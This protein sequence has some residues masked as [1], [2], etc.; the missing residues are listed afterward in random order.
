MLRN[1]VH[2]LAIISLLLISAP[3]LAQEAQVQLQP[4]KVALAGVSTQ[5][6]ATGSIESLPGLAL[7]TA[8]QR[9]VA[10]IADNTAVF[11][12]LTLPKG[13]S[14]LDLELDG[15][16]V[17][18]VNLRVLPAW[19]S[20][21]PPLVAI[22]MTLLSRQVI[23]AL[24]LGVWFGSVA[25]IGFT[26]AGIFHGLLAT[27][28]VHV[29]GAV[30]DPSQAQVLLFSFMIGGMIGIVIKNGGMQGVVNIIVRFATDPRRG[31]LTTAFLGLAVFFDG[32]ANALVVGNTMRQV[33]DRL[34]ISREKLAYIVDST[35]APV[36]SVA[37]VSTW[38]GFQVGLIGTILEQIGAIR[39][40]AY[41]IFLNSV[42]Y[43]FYPWLTI[44]MVFMLATSGREF[45]PMRVAEE[46]AR[47]ANIGLGP[48][49][50]PE[51]SATEASKL[52]NDEQPPVRAINSVVP[53]L[54]L[55]AG[56][57]G[58]L[59]ATGTGDSIRDIIGT[60]D[61]NTALMWGSLLAV[62]VAVAMTICQRI[63]PLEE[64]V[65][66]WYSGLRQ[67]LHALI[68]LVLAWSLAAVVSELHTASYLVS[69]LGESL[70]PGLVP[71]MVF[72]LAAAT[73]FATGSSWAT[74]GIL[75]PLVMPL[76][77]AVLSA[78]GAQDQMHIMYSAVSCVISGAVLGD[79]ISPISD[80][81]ILSSMAAGC[82][83]IEHVRTQL[84]YALI[85]GAVAVVLGTVPAGYG[86]PWWI[87]MLFGVGTI[88]SI[89]RC[90]G[91]PVVVAVT[92]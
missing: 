58:G 80:T 90:V 27:Y 5:V 59:W 28:T 13:L 38:I 79:H 77:W 85:V 3:L 82:D 30:V 73:A 69:A 47:K 48:A 25:L 18:T 36:T 39:E 29:L 23:P 15:V 37:V 64:I 6:R 33:T 67:M 91:K 65:N 43:S 26:P 76:V 78:A 9:Y 20:I 11:A 81:T 51:A 75:M 62:T 54:V 50:S 53:I 72:V 19:V 68:I 63:L 45:G 84:P 52:H 8:G 42:A 1:S 56:V 60:A 31:Q 41:S 70:A 46:R 32:Y 71:S 61:S 40:S 17:D 55:I 21:V 4:P 87:G 49:T 89:V 83:H 66:A 22:V 74:M 7:R 34:R 35:C 16:V 86:V 57:L 12:E 2:P 14:R 10:T 24:F 88:Y 92:D 44:I